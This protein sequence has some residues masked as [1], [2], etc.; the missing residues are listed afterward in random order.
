MNRRAIAIALSAFALTTVASPVAALTYTPT[1]FDDPVPNGCLATDCSLREAVIA[2]NATSI[3]DTIQLQAGKYTLTLTTGSETQS[4][5]LDVTRPLTI[6]GSATSSTYIINA[7]GVVNAQSRVVDVRSTQLALN[8]VGLRSGDVGTEGGGCLRVVGGGASLEA[9]SI[10][11]CNAEHGSAADAIN[12]TLYLKSSTVTRNT[13][14][15]IAL[16]NVTFTL[17]NSSVYGNVGDRGGGVYVYGEATSYVFATGISEIRDNEASMGGGVLVEAGS[18]AEIVGPTNGFLGIADNEAIIGGGISGLHGYVLL[19]NLRITGNTADV[20]AGLHTMSIDARRIQVDGNIATSYGGGAYV[21]CAG[22]Q[23]QCRIT[24]S[25]FANNRAGV[26]GGGIDHFS[27]NL[28]EI[29][30]V[31][32]YGNSAGQTG[33]GIVAD[34]GVKLTHVT[35]FQDFAP[36]GPSLAHVS[37]GGTLSASLVR[38]SALLEGCATVGAVNILSEGGNTQRTGTPTCNFTAI[39]DLAPVTAVQVGATYGAF[40]GGLSVVGIPATSVL[41]NAGK[42]SWCSSIDVRGYG[43]PAMCDIG[44]YEVGASSQT[45]Q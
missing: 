9:G 41:V 33:G 44:A 11:L 40:G 2:A 21:G 29:T 19:R 13:G 20:G 24:E 17:D 18:N 14:S 3:A 7:T 28:L 5:D 16:S 45:G 30:N 38:N 27:G 43:R 25:S 12:S 10:A 42:A 23:W 8:R 15:A 6:A 36:I 22:I 37:N 4:F 32:L 31:S 35:S 26:K 1:R 34:G 39:G